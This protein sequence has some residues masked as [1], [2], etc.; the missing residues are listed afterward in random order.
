M[1]S[2]IKIRIFYHIEWKNFWFEL[3]DSH[4]NAL[5]LVRI[6]KTSD[7]IDLQFTPNLTFHCV[8]LRNESRGILH[9]YF[10][11]FPGHSQVVC[12][13]LARKEN[14]CSTNL[15]QQPEREQ[16]QKTCV[17]FFFF[18]K[19]NYEWSLRRFTYEDLVTTSPSYKQK[20]SFNFPITQSVKFTFL[21][22]R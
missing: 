8:L 14:F 12:C 16:K 3:S 13:R 4:E 21:F 19:I 17:F 18:I 15:R 6:R 7:P 9:V 22:H 20:G 5:R 2:E 10:K 1:T 11:L